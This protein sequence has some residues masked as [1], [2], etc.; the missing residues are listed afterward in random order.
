MSAMKTP[1][2]Q[3]GTSRFLQAHADLFIDEALAIGNAVGPI[4][5]VQSSGNAE[6][7][8]RVKALADPG[9]YPV[10]IR[11]LEN[12]ETVDR[13][14]T[15]HSVRRGLSTA[16]DWDVVVGLMCGEITHVI[17]NTGE[18]GFEPREAD[19][20][21]RFDQ[22]MSYP[23]KLQLLLWARYHAGEKPL[24]IFPT[25]L[26]ERNGD[27]LRA[28]ILEL[29]GT[30]DEGYVH[31][32]NT[33]VIWA[34][35]LVDRIV[36]EPI[37]PAG[38]VAEPYGLW[39]IEKTPGLVPP[40]TH[41]MVQ[42]FDR[43]EKPLSLKL[44][45]LNLSHTCLIHEWQKDQTRAETTREFMDIDA[46]REALIDLLEAEVMPGFVAA[47]M[48]DDAAPYMKTTI[49]RIR[50]PYLDHYLRDIAQNHD[51]KVQFRIQAFIDW[52]A[53]AGDTTPK[54]RLQGIIDAR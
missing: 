27:V 39:A 15:V 17:S 13:T 14:Q 36:S 34:N 29:A 24:Q 53:A 2:L 35:S 6:R 12:G 31:W 50:N 42:L 45:I 26:V 33:Q 25:E 28:R 52:S 30:A 47:G 48:G 19:L 20:A 51:K 3:F 11:G 7:A 43:L 18:R 40:C 9:G 37:E 23:A 44:F 4:T 8:G 10:R 46:V 54:P 5:V 1:I 16:T 22:D 38:A 32:L 41:P 21:S 49:E